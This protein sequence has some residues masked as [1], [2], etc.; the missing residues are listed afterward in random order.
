MLELI[1]AINICIA[2]SDI[3]GLEKPLAQ[4]N[5]IIYYLES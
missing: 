4:L 3:A 1:T 2:D 5:D